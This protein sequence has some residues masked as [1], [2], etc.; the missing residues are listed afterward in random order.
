ML[1]RLLA[2]T[3]ILLVI[4]IFSI[5]SSKL[6]FESN[7]P[8][9]KVEGQNSVVLN[10]SVFTLFTESFV[11]VVEA[12]GYVSRTFEGNHS[13]GINKIKLEKNP[14]KIDF[15]QL[16][17][18]PSTIFINGIEYSEESAF[19]NEGE[20]EIYLEF[21]EFLPLSMNILIDTESS[22]L[23]NNNLTPINKKILFL[24]LNEE[25]KI[26]VN[27]KEINTSDILNLEKYFNKLTVRR[28]NKTI[29]DQTILAD[30]ND[31][32]EILL[33]EFSKKTPINI[34]QKDVDVYLNNKFI[35]NSIS[36]LE[37]LSEEDVISFS[38][39]KYYLKEIEYK[40]QE[41]LDVDLKPKLG[42]LLI[43]NTQNAKAT[44]F[45]KELKA[46]QK[47]VELLIGNYEITFEADGFAPESK[48]I[49]IDEN[50]LTEL[51][52][53]LLTF[54]ESAIKNSKKKYTNQTGIN[55]ILNS[56]G[57][58]II[59][60]DTS[61]FRRNKN[62]IR[63]KVEITRHFYL[64][65]SLITNKQYNKIMGK[66]G[67]D[68]LPITN[69]TWIMAAIFCNE[70][71]KKEGFKPFYIINNSKLLGF[72]ISSNGYRLPTESE[73]EFVI[74]MPN[75]NGEKQKIYPWGN[76]TEL[77]ETI[78]NLSDKDSGN[79]NIIN[80]YSDSHKKL[81]P[82]DS[83]F[84]TASGYY[85]FLGNAK[86]WVNDFYTEEISIND[87]N[88]IRDYIGPNFGKTH[89]IKGSSYRSFNLSELGISYRDD[90]EKGQE[91]LGFRV[92]RWIY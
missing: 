53:R 55:L 34:V 75:A 5:K 30:N 71:S 9:L 66:T 41:Y 48:I 21:N 19:L 51:D 12:D 78:A 18:L 33:E 35:G 43:K 27:E 26:Y 15:S 29:Y 39:K 44:L 42:S 56:P 3:I 83:Y 1:F 45:S 79:K 17:Q 64:S 73:W 14:I 86:E 50:K 74:S 70:L 4:S 16:K 57:K 82:S 85:D 38:K 61:E 20:N 65:D 63:R 77:K 60:S 8:D 69:I 80:G 92:A 24:N 36:Y 46:F 90:S 2:L 58:I 91:D 87:K 7:Y 54:K 47:P 13:M 11:V 52:I 25:D 88:F 67:G 59:G 6:E 76:D 31:S 28:Q 23:L 62:E 68:D 10:E 72:D 81:S 40:D 22:Y 37:N 32:Y 49:T 89:V 84:K